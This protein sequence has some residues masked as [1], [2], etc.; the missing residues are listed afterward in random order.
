MLAIVI[1][2]APAWSRRLKRID[3]LVDEALSAL[4]VDWRRLARERS[5]KPERFASEWQ[6]RAQQTDFSQVNDLIQRHN[7][8]FPA[9]ANLAMDVHTGDYIGLGGGDFRRQP[10]D[11][12]W[13]LHHFPADLSLALNRPRQ[14]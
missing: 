12:A 8:Y 6:A 1:G 9:E 10:L 2:G 13:V 11:A 14:T 3:T 5:R 7:V 4:E